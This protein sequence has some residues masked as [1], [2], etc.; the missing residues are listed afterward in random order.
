MKK[1]YC[2]AAAVMCSMCLLLSGCGNGAGET[3][4]TKF[5]RTGLP[6]TDE[7]VTLEIAC[8]RTGTSGPWGEMPFF[9]K[10][11]EKTNVKINWR[12]FPDPYKESV[13]LMFASQDFPDA[14]MRGA[15]DAQVLG[16]AAAKNV[17]S[18]NDL[19]DK[20]APRWKEVL[21][22]D[23]YVRKVVT[24]PDGNIYSL[25][26]IR[27]DENDYGMRDGWFINKD[28]LDKLGLDIPVTTDDFYNVL[29]AFRDASENGTLPADIIPWYFRYNQTV[30]G[31]Y[32][33]FASFGSQDNS[34]HIMV[35]NG[36][37]VSTMTKPES[38]DAIQYLHKLYSEGLIPGDVFTDDYAT[39]VKKRGSDPAVTGVNHGYYNAYPEHYAAF[40]PPASPGVEKGLVRQ[41]TTKVL[42]NQ[43]IIFANNKYPEITMR[44]ADELADPD[45]SVQALY[46][47]F[48]THI[49]K[50]QDGK[51]RFL[52]TQVPLSKTSPINYAPANITPS[53]IS[54]LVLERSDKQRAEDYKNIYKNNTVSEDSLYPPVVFT[55]EQNA[56]IAQYTTQLNTYISE[57]VAKWIVSG[58]VE[59]DWD[60]FQ[61]KLQSMKLNELLGI[62]QE[63]LDAFN[64]N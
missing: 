41:Q 28:W 11:E 25:P 6:I 12:E 50:Q 4:E 22:K 51:I 62:Y 56:K 39:Y 49:E 64:K 10:L 7:P 20:Y 1:K 32:D 23:D 30:G 63:A 13:N 44:W 26:F 46:G 60:A 34:N 55:E 45:N 48:G 29:K 9:K 24:M 5:N 27:M 58:G 15:E 33:I 19:I 2:G 18:L 42:R 31:Q 59:N 38:R 8:V 35:E 43:M 40:L 53:I 36:K 37:V 16:A 21:E 14:M 54:S 61:K 47:M 3:A 57:T 17:I 52:E